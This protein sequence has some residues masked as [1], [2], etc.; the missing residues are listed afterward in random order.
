MQAVRKGEEEAESEDDTNGLWNGQPFRPLPAVTLPDLT[1]G[2]A[3]AMS[4]QVH[5]PAVCKCL[6][7]LL[8]V[9]YH[10]N[11][12]PTALSAT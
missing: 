2:C 10:L 3:R 5:L 8:S 12:H 11:K 7:L 6:F 4:L 9:S 1:A